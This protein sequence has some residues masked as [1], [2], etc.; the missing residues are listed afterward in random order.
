MSFRK[1]SPLCV[2]GECKGAVHEKGQKSEAE[3]E[4]GVAVIVLDHMEEKTKDEWSK[5]IE[6]SPIIVG[7]DRKDK[8]C[9]HTWRQ[10]KE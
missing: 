6:S 2:E 7:V 8:E 1:W 10:G 3:M 5:G 4:Q 9:S